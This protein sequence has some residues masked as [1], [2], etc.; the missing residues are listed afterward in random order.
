MNSSFKKSFVEIADTLKNGIEHIMG[1][2]LQMLQI[3]INKIYLKHTNNYNYYNFKYKDIQYLV[4]INDYIK[5]IYITPNIKIKPTG[6]AI[7]KILKTQQIP[8]CPF[9][10]TKFDNPGDEINDMFNSRIDHTIW[11]YLRCEM[12]DYILPEVIKDSIT[13]PYNFRMKSVEGIK[14]LHERKGFVKY[15]KEN[16]Y[17]VKEIVD[18]TNNKIKLIEKNAYKIL[19][20][21]MIKYIH[22]KDLVMMISHYY[23]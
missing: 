7:R 8:L 23:I 9:L 15:N 2:N 16:N 10:C 19:K 20:E 11:F 17:N 18:D 4:I 1:A 13:T 12:N 14:E 5:C 21:L 6:N 22:I 3:D